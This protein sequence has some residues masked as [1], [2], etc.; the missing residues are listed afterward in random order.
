MVIRSQTSHLPHPKEK[1]LD[2][3]IINYYTNYKY[4]NLNFAILEDKKFKSPPSLNKFKIYNG[5]TIEKNI[6]AKDY[7]NDEFKLLGKKQLNF[8]QTWSGQAKKKKE[9]KIILT[10]SAYASLT[11]VQVDYTPLKDRPAKKDSVPQKVSPDMDTNGWPKIGRDKAL[12]ALQD[13]SILFISGDQHMGAVIDVFDSSN[14]NYTFF[15]VP[16][17][18]NTWPRMWWPNNNGANSKYPLGKYID[19]FGNNIKVRAVANPNPNAPNPNSINRKSPGF[20]IIEF[21]KKGHKALLHAYPL[22]FNS[23]PTIQ[24]FKGWPVEVKL[25]D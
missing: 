6:T 24:E 15:S 19:A 5:F 22:Y 21:N 4:G 18:A 13:S 14:T 17:I 25:K 16:A 7:H 2:N 10:Q 1:R 11:T 9:F 8:L 23:Y 20:G 12:E 3:G